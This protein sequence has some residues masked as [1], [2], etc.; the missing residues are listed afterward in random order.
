MAK[1]KKKKK[2]L[3]RRQQK[4]AMRSRKA[5][6]SAKS[7]K[8]HLNSHP[9]VPP[10]FRLGVNEEMVMKW[11]DDMT[12]ILMD[13]FTLASEP[14]FENL[15]FDLISVFDLTAKYLPQ[16][17]ECFKEQDEEKLLLQRSEIY[18]SMLEELLTPEFK[19]TVLDLLD[20]VIQRKQKS[21]DK[22]VY[23]W[24]YIKK[25]LIDAEEDIWTNCALTQAIL[26][27]TIELV[28][29]LMELI[30]KKKDF[31]PADIKA[32]LEEAGITDAKL[33][34]IQGLTENFQE[35]EDDFIV[36]T[37]AD[38][39]EKDM[40]IGLFTEEDFYAYNQ[41]L[42][43]NKSKYEAF[44]HGIEI[45]DIEPSDEV[46]QAILDEI[47]ETINDFLSEYLTE[48]HLHRMQKVIH[49]R[50]SEVTSWRY[51]SFYKILLD[52]IDDY[53]K[54]KQKS[55]AIALLAM[56]MTVELKKLGSSAN[57]DFSQATQE[58]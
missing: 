17:E 41:Y 53:L 28:L 56:V 45:D 2:I 23:V 15:Y 6:T 49:E 11:M 1:K 24:I 12:S 25:M 27:K 54:H 36:D 38:M 57:F 9:S 8:M 19:E 7:R 44:F 50:L 39:Y 10:E 4:R 13:D 34:Q 52:S 40:I 42:E 29:P 18:A 55:G 32:V 26:D 37:L 5:R 43:Q 16:L 51:E 30:N 47:N 20:Q 14:E 22:N 33:E 31:T 58:G 3:K 21:Q 48:Q 35:Y 46:A